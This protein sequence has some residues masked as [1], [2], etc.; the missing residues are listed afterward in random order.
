MAEYKLKKEQEILIILFK[1]FLSF[2]N[3]RNI[4][5]LIGISHAGAFKILKK[6]ESKS[7][8]FGKRIGKAIIY[9]LNFNNPVAKKELEMALAIE[10]QN[11][12]RWLE[13]FKEIENKAEFAIL[14]GSIIKNEDKSRDI[15]L[16]VVAKKE[17]F[18]E[19]KRI[20][21]ARNKFLNKKIHLI[22][23]SV[24]EFTHDLNNKNKALV[25]IIKTGIILFKQEN[26]IK[27]F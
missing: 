20:I 11:N 5:K 3:S 6:L 19:I 24:E 7:I 10:A 8:V 15:D 16:L 21:E 1:D 25:E 2:Y 22:L 18:E 14:F 23:Q 9:S 17:S 4:S 26:I 27:A 12:K 13:E